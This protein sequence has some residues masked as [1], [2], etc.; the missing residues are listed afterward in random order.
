MENLTF[1]I[2]KMMS[3]EPAIAAC[4]GLPYLLLQVAE[5]LSKSEDN[6]LYKIV[7]EKESDYLKGTQA[8]HKAKRKEMVVYMKKDPEERG[9]QKTRNN[10]SS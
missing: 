1:S 10:D 2:K 8:H 4:K 6:K 5:L 3:L 7:V 9:R